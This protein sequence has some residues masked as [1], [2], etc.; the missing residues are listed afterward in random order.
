MT[1]SRCPCRDLG[2]ARRRGPRDRR[3]APRRPP[4]RVRR[5]PGR[6]PRAA[7][8]LIAGGAPRTGARRPRPHARHPRRHRRRAG[9][10]PRSPTSERALRWVLAAIGILQ[11]AVAIPALVLGEDADLPVH[12]ARHLGSFEVALGVGFLF[13]AW[14]P[15]RAAGILPVVAA[16]VVCLVGSSLLDVL[17]GTTAAGTEVHHAT[18]VAGL[19]VVW[20]LSRAALARPDGGAG[21]RSAWRE[22]SSIR[23]GAPPRRTPGGARVPDGPRA[24]RHRACPRPRTP[25]CSRSTPNRVV[26]TTS[27]PTAVHLR[28]SEPV[29][30]ALGGVRVF[31]GRRRPRRRRHAEHP[32]GRS[33]EVRASLPDLDDGTYVVTWRVTSADSHP[34][35]GAFTFQVG[36][37]RDRARRR[38]P[39]GAAARAAG[40]EHASSASSTRSS[41]RRC[42][43]RSRS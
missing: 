35:E 11:I 8:G 40:R 9:R 26:P 27:R 3:R 28:F 42:T 20:L 21:P 34:V 29:E 33:D 39:R 31:D 13:A 1:C 16:L 12:I 23:P 22:P 18:D 14:K 10:G 30:V 38:G 6:S 37:H 32:G 41:A 15:Q 43:P 25:R 5:L 19:V 24:R 36:R 7:E 2:P 4:R 17:A